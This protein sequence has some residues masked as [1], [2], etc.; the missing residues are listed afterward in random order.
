M[1]LP[2]GEAVTIDQSYFAFDQISKSAEQPVGDPVNQPFDELLIE[3]FEAPA[4]GYMLV[5][6]SNESNTLI[7]VHFDNIHISLE[8]KEIVQADDYYPFGLTFNSYRR[9]GSSKNDYLY[10]GK[11][12]MENTDWYDFRARGYHPALGR[13]MQ[14]DPRYNGPSGYVGMMNNPIMNVDPNGEEPVTLGVGAVIAI[15]AAVS[16]VSYTASI[17]LSDDGFNNWDWGQFSQNVVVG[18]ISGAISYGIGTAFATGSSTGQS[19]LR[20]MGRIATHAVVQ[21]GMSYAQ[22]GNFWMAAAS[23][24]IGG[25]VGLGTEN[26]TSTGGKIGTVGIAML[27]G[28]TMAELSGGDFWKGAAIAGIVAAANDVA[29]RKA[30]NIAQKRAND[31]KSYIFIE[32]MVTPK[33][34]N[35]EQYIKDLK[36]ALI[37]S[38]FS[39]NLIIAE[40]SIIKR[41]IAWW[42]D[43]PTATVTIRNYDLR[44]KDPIDAGGVL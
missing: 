22:G 17:A 14:V 12:Q 5:Y 44:K 33:G 13:F 16:A 41:L 18:A 30:Q 42:N 26:W 38:G 36:A 11:E 1:F 15:S 10:Q 37:A 32:K 19:A 9:I 8:Q 27:M 40:S 3:D 29:H 35:K 20:E 24:A 7:D 28:G 21:G 39:K 25:A 31:Q 2:E 6:I 4:Q 34:F 43:S 23:G